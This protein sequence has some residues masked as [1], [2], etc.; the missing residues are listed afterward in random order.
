MKKSRGLSFLALVALVLLAPMIGHAEGGTDLSEGQTIY[1][2]AYS[3]IYVGNRENPFL[4]TVTL[5]IRNIDTKHP[6]TIT[7]ADYYDTKGKRIRKYLEQP[8]S[9]GP[10]ESIRYVVPQKDKSG[11]SGANFIVE[12]TSTKAVNPLF[13]ETIMIG[14]ESQQGISFTSSGKAISTEN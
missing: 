3:H 9:L 4:L 7:A 11:G 13:V 2:P 12:W 8:V 14:A 10:L 6:V 1:V 5:S